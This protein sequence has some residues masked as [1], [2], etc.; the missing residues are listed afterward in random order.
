[1]T[2]EMTIYETLAEQ[3]ERASV[4]ETE[5]RVERQRYSPL[6]AKIDVLKT[7]LR[8]L[9]EM[10]AVARQREQVTWLELYRLVDDLDLP[11]MTLDD[12]LLDNPSDVLTVLERRIERRLAAA[13]EEGETDVDA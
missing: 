10:Y 6:E 2:E 11:P 5:R 4:I 12:Q 7:E 9:Q 1:M 13:A 3:R 8:E